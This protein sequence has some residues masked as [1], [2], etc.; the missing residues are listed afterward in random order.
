MYD[1]ESTGSKI[2][3]CIESFET[4]SVPPQGIINNKK[5]TNDIISN[6]EIRSK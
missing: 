2:I 6:I 5:G 4:Y 3:P 1:S